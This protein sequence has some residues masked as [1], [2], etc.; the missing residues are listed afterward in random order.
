ME[1]D[2]KE[3]WQI[4][5]LCLALPSAPRARVCFVPQPPTRAGRV[6]SCYRPGLAGWR[7]ELPVVQH[8]QGRQNGST[9]FPQQARNHRKAEELSGMTGVGLF[10]PKAT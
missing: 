4:S 2:K 1:N 7:R 5:A 6:M 8:S 9:P 3:D 10:K